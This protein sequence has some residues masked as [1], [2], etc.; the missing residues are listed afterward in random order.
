M[1]A[2]FDGLD[3]ADAPVPRDERIAAALGPKMLD[4]AAERSLGTHPYFTTPEHTRFARERVGPDALVAP[5]A[6]RRGRDRRRARPRGRAR[7]RRA[8]TSGSPT[9]RANLLRF[10]FTEA[11]IAD[12]GSDRLI[13]AVIPHGSRRGDRRGGPGALRRRRRPRLP[14]AARPRP[15]AGRRLP[16]AR[17]RSCSNRGAA[18]GR[19]ALPP[20]RT[21]GRALRPASPPAPRGW[22][23]A[24]VADPVRPLVELGQRALGAL[25]RDL[26]RATHAD[27]GQPAD[28]LDRAVADPL[29]EA[30]RGRQLGVLG[31]PP[32]AC[33][34]SRSASSS[35]RTELE[36]H[37][38]VAPSSSSSSSCAA[39][40]T[41]LWRHSAAR[42]WHAIRP[43]RWMRRKSP[44]TKP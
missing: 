37:Q 12:G 27:L 21:P 6:R 15:G 23:A 5:G 36:V 29:A 7:L 25:Q 31:E 11:D 20:P 38:P 13:D 14:A 44:N 34:R 32:R 2:F 33:A 22:L 3:A 1:R 18:A 41:D 16:G 28:R 19:A 8:R 30:L 35:W 9:T 43:E 42:Y 24:G 10:G 4:L 17:A 40:S 39:S 26:E